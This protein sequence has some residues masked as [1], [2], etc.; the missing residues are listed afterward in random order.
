MLIA[1]A[2]SSSGHCPDVWTPSLT[3]PHP[4]KEASFWITICRFNWGK[5][6][7]LQNPKFSNHLVNSVLDLVFNVITDWWFIFFLKQTICCCWRN[8]HWVF[9]CSTACTMDERRPITLVDSKRVIEW[10]L[11]SFLTTFCTFS[12]VNDQ[13]ILIESISIPRNS[14]FWHGCKIDFLISLP[15]A[16]IANSGHALNSRQNVLVPNVTIFFK[17]LLNNGQIF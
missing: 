6:W 1:P 15:I 16:D 4:F 14:I 11:R 10:L 5:A 17:L 13:V 7:P 3:A 2:Y 12:G 9:T 8:R